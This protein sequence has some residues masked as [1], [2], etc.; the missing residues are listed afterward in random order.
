[1]TDQPPKKKRKLLIVDIGED[2]KPI[3]DPSVPQQRLAG[4][5]ST[6]QQ[7]QKYVQDLAIHFQ[8]QGQVDQE[9]WKKVDLVLTAQT[10]EEANALINAASQHALAFFQGAAGGSP[11]R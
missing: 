10:Q 3:V 8:F 9:V 11:G 7:L 5:E 1:M 2:G 6:H 4:I